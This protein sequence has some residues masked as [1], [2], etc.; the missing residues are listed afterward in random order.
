MKMSRKM[1]DYL[2]FLV[3]MLLQQGKSVC[4]ACELCLFS[5]NRTIFLL[6]TDDRYLIVLYVAHQVK[7]GEES[8]CLH[9]FCWNYRWDCIC[10]HS[11]IHRPAAFRRMP[12]YNL[13]K[14]IVSCDVC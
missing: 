12:L 8:G 5:G 6:V 9:T 4:K 14:R 7:G 11:R 3:S 1:V 2:R 10:D 13:A